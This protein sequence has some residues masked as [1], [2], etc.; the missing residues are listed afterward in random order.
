L[1]FSQEQRRGSKRNEVIIAVGK[2]EHTGNNFRQAPPLEKIREQARRYLRAGL[3]VIPVPAGEKNPDRPGWQTE[4]WRIEDVPRLWD[5]GQGIGVLWGEPSAGLVDVDCDWPEARAVARHIAPPTRS[6][7]REGGPAAHLV[8]RSEGESP[9]TRRYLISGKGDDQ[10]VVE[11]LSTGAQSLAPPS[12]HGESGERRRW[13]DNRSAAT[14]EGEECAAIAA[15]IATAALLL[16]NYPGKGAR[17]HYV[18]AATG[19]IGRRLPRARAERVMVAVI[20][21]SGDEE[22]TSRRRDV[23]DTLD[24]IERGEPTTGG[25]TLEEVAS[26]VAGQLR[27]WHGWGASEAAS[28][29]LAAFNRT[30][31]GNAERL[32]AR[33]GEHLRYCH[34]WKKWLFWNG[35]RWAVDECGRTNRLAAETVRSIY[36]EAKKEPD[37]DASKALARHAIASESRTRIDAMMALAQSQPG[38]PVVPDNLDA[39]MWLLNCENGTVDLRTGELR[40][41]RREDLLT[42]LSPVAYD[43]EARAPTFDAFLGRVLPSEALRRFLRKAL[44]YAAVGVVTE[45]MLVILHGSGDNGK[46]T[47]I[48]AI[49][50]ALGDYA[51]QAAR[52]LLLL[53]RGAHPTELTDLFGTRFVACSE[54]D[55]GRRM[56]EA[57]V[58]QLTGRE[59]IRARGMREDF[60]EFDPTHTV[61][62]ATNHRPEIR[63]TDHA[64][65]RRIKLVP[66]EVKIPEA[67]KDKGLP[68]KLR[69]ELPGILAW[70]VRGSLDYQRVG[71]GEPEEVTQAIAGYRAEMDVLST[72]IADRC[73]IKDGAEAPATPLYKA[74]KEW[75]EEAGEQAEKQT[76]FGRRLGERG[77]I[78]F[79]FSQGPYKGR[80]GWR[81]IGLRQESE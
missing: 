10:M 28:G 40:E 13:Y 67:E 1:T 11:L 64:I 51:I 25:P 47:L 35:K 12:L 27:R 17:H 8:L 2:T 76:A 63:G 4:R 72:F 44:G 74:Y 31:L 56:A 61:F 81:G 37:P 24:K 15:D 54:T 73:V 41:H 38:I 6:F 58:K 53:K 50:E 34:P 65:W 55:D 9:K 7:G 57:L 32:A 33:H 19:C 30:D 14:V 20:V 26:G 60:W 36:D 48:N 23:W 69:A 70:I 66:F 59:R 21:A 29:S 18:L 3:A 52:D 62:L 77:F 42:K 5:D 49:L 43:E 16:R 39:D 79:T 80:K 45:E 75:C 46:T 78:S 68:E 22:A 71:L